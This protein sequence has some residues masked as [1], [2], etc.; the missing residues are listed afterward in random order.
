LVEK[1]IG[2]FKFL[3]SFVEN[4]DTFLSYYLY[5][6][7]LDQN[8]KEFPCNLTK[9]KVFFLE[10]GSGI[11]LLKYKMCTVKTKFSNLNPKS[12]Y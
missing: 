3:N 9:K 7:R 8:Q 11:F 5:M 4:G 2:S 6:S 1:K 10:T 12:S